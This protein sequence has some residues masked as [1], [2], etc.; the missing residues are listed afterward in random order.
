MCGSEPPSRVLLPTDFTPKFYHL[1][2]EPDFSTFKYHGQCDISL[3]VNEPTDTLV[4]NSIDQEI[5]RVEIE[6]IGLAEVSYDKDAETATFKFPKKIDLDEVKVKITFVGILNDLLNGFYRSSY[7]E[8][9]EKKY[10]ATTHMEPASCRRAFPCFDEPALKAVFNI[11]LIADKHLTCLSNM[12][13]RNEE[14]HGEKKKVVFKPTPLMSTYLVAFVVGE[15]DYV[16]DSVNYRLPVRVYS[17]PGKAHK[18]KFAAEYGAKT[19]TYFE[20]IFGIDVPVEKVDL[21]GIPDFAIGAMENWGLITFRD[22]ALLYDPE[23]CSLSQKQ[24]CAEIVMHELAHQWF[25]N[26]VTMDWWEGLWLK[27]GFATWMSFLAMDHFF[28][29]WNIWE[30]FYTSN[31]VRA[32]DLDCLRSSH[33]IEVNVRTAKELP[34]IFDAISYSKGGSVLRMISDYLGLDIFLK[35]ISKYLSDHAYGC[36]VTTDLWDALAAASGKDVVSIMTT[37][38]KKVGYPYVKVENGEKETKLTQH[39]FLSSNDVT[40]EEDTLYPV[41]LE[42]LDASTGKVDKSLELRERTTSIPTPFVFKLN[43]N[44]VGTYRTL[45]PSALISLLVD[46]VHLSTFDRAGLVDDMT[47]FASCGLAPTTE[48]LKLLSAIKGNDSLIVWEMISGAFGELEALLRFADKAT[49]LKLRK[50]RLFVLSA[51]PFD[52]TSWPEDEDELVQQVKALLFAF[53]VSSEHPAV[54]GY[55]KGL[56]DS[57]IESPTTKINPNIMGTVF[58]AGVSKGGEAEWLQLLKIAQT[59]TDSVIPNKAFSALGETPLPELKLKTLQLTLDGSVRNQDFL[60]PVTGVVASAEG[61]RIYW[62]WF[63]SNWDKIVAFLPPNGIGNILPRAVGLSISRFTSQEDKQ[64]AEEFYKGR[65]EDAFA[66]SLDQAFELVTTRIEWLKR[67]EVE[68]G[69]FLGTV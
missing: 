22:A 68:I 15:L 21:I 55:A 62:D 48:L 39:R 10:L 33:P 44:Q 17:T 29:Q 20:K 56:F 28:P 6:E 11:T 66:R 50:L 5:S 57:Y 51:A 42:L 40:P 46:S 12:A 61:V 64:K 52:L 69:E 27:E 65:K 35:G 24:H 60:Y 1:T 16:E 25:G 58:K 43:A 31:V 53:A 54:T 26:L 67:D 2:L 63:T 4:L 19:L 13:V 3:E 59:S 9:G 34:Q 45:Y 49:L 7:T 18:G 38:T 14:P 8:N 37:W 30:S 32:L 23:T 41:L 47:A 36:T